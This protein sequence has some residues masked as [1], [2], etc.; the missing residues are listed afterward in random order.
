MSSPQAQALYEE[1]QFDAAAQAYLKL[2]RHDRR[3]RSYYRLQAAQAW[4][5]EGEWDQARSALKDLR[6]RDLDAEEAFLLDLLH[7]E[8]ALSDGDLQA[9]SDLLV[10]DPRRVPADL[11]TRLLELRARTFEASGDP[12]SAARER[13]A[14]DGLL[15][16]S[17]RVDN[18]RAT[19][20]LLDQLP[21]AERSQLLR[22]LER[23]DPLYAWLL[24]RTPLEGAGSNSYA[25]ELGA[26]PLPDRHATAL[27]PVQIPPAP[28]RRLALLLPM[29]GD[30]A[31]A[32]QAIRDGVF[33]GYYSEPGFRPEIQIYDSGSTPEDA[34]AAFDR[35]V[36]E[37]ADRVLGPFPREQVGA[38]FR[39]G[40]SVPTLALNYAVAPALPPPG[41]LQFALLPEE[42]AIA[43]A[44]YMREQGM[45]QVAALVPDDDFGRRTL[46]AFRVRFQS[47]GGTVTNPQYFNPQAT[48]NAP[49]IRAALGLN[50]SNSRAQQVQ[51]VT[52]LTL[53]AQPSRRGDLDGIFLSA[54]PPQARQLL[55]QI[56]QYDGAQWPIYATS[57]VYA[58]V[59]SMQ[60][61][62]LNGVLFVDA[63]WLY[64]PIGNLPNRQQ[65]AALSAT[66][67][68]AVRLFAFGLDAW[69]MV[70]RI[71]W[72]EEHAGEVLQGATGKLA[73]DGRGSIRRQGVWRRFVDGRAEAA[74]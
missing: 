24:K 68:P 32:G 9:A 47:L 33:A 61:F 29:K 15:D 72:L 56:R 30:L 44:E 69:A 46:D 8:M 62:D 65:V 58:G 55:P 57:H 3:Q 64:E 2:A 48:D 21:A 6:R 45:D 1:G 25:N 23:G 37:G 31:A 53:N 12:L 20:A 18:A 73:S 17:D 42:E 35:A 19:G 52:G 41:S 16:G 50:E 38:L 59:P 43:V 11:E 66:Q 14:L 51:A 63:P 34:L 70:A 71:E 28:F 67:G 27:D 22:T 40:T 7:A 26:A 39:R 60:D 10:V 4:R 13:I 74:P 36:A 5:E 49:A 54:R